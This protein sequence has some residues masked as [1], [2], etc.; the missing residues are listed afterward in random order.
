MAQH[1]II[2]LNLYTVSENIALLHSKRIGQVNLIMMTDSA[3]AR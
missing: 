1:P 3:L 2:Q